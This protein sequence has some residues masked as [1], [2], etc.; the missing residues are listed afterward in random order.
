RFGSDWCLPSSPGWLSVQWAPGIEGKYVL[1]FGRAT[2]YGADPWL[3]TSVRINGM[4]PIPIRGMSGN[5]MVLIELANNIIIRDLRVDI[6]GRDHPG[7]TGIEIHGAKAG[8]TVAEN[9]KSTGPD[10]S[11]KNPE[12][13]SKKTQKSTARPDKI[14]GVLIE[15]EL[16]CS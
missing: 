2:P 4:K 16:D 13:D 15:G 11:V 8:N 9:P 7:I 3:E 1:I 14:N 12:A 5:H 6:S 10:K